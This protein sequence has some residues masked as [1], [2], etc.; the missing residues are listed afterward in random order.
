ML[1]IYGI[2][3][4][5]KVDLNDVVKETMKWHFSDKTGSDFWLS[6]KKE[7][8]FDPLKD[9]NT[10][11]DLFLFNDYVDELKKVDV[12]CLIPR[13]IK[14][15]N[16][17]I[18]VFESGGT[19]GSPQR[20]P[21]SF[22]RQEALAW[23]EKHLE[24]HGITRDMEGDWIHI[25][26]LGPHIVGTSV[27]RLAHGRNKLCYYI[28]FDPRW[29]KYVVKIGK[30]ES[31]SDYVN[32]ILIQ[33][34]YLLQT[35]NISVMLVTPLILE[36][37]SND[38]ELLNLVRDKIKAIIWAGTS[39]DEETLNA[40]QTYIFKDMR[41]MGIY[42][43]TLMGISPQRLYEKNDVCLCTFQSYY[44]Y[45]IVEVVSED[46]R[47]NLV[48]Y[49]SKG[50]VCIT[51]MTPDLFIPKHL[52]RDEAYRVKPLESYRGDGVAEIRP[53]SKYK[54]KIFEGVY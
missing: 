39:L 36:A 7:F 38:S 28:D 15:L 24:A 45:S 32:H 13:G 27:G 46:D 40:Y 26:P 10:F 11:D 1:D 4:C 48:D 3:K 52:E 44:P 23:V 17:N 8:R 41:M 20:I 50:Q 33:V 49:N 5:E 14:Q 35:Q 37:I 2:D 42:G 21:D 47:T 12:N 34:K 18:N 54:N 22:S 6:K 30:K 53:L 9:I 25:G 43:N 16:Y 19:T 31:V 29:V 51:L